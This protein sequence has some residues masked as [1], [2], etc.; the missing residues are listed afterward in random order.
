MI[1]PLLFSLVLVTHGLV[2]VGDVATLLH[3]C[4]IKLHYLFLIFLTLYR[5][6]VDFS[7]SYTPGDPYVV[8]VVTKV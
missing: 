6:Y 1:M 4:R 3:F 7:I 8:S 2:K 5:C